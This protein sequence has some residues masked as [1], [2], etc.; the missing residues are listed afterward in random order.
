MILKWPL[1]H[2]RIRKLITTIGH[3]GIEIVFSSP[4]GFKAPNATNEKDPTVAYRLLKLVETYENN[5]KTWLKNYGVRIN[6]TELKISTSCGNQQVAATEYQHDR[7][8]VEKPNQGQSKPKEADVTQRLSLGTKTLYLA[9]SNPFE[10]RWGAGA[11]RA[12][13]SIVQFD[14]LTHLWI[15]WAMVNTHYNKNRYQPLDDHPLLMVIDPEYWS[16]LTW[17]LAQRP[18]FWKFKKRRA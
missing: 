12:S 8:C 5:T 10:S 4:K 13:W 1:L 2:Q 3:V 7:K 9:Q 15:T 16:L 6:I 18:L 11:P 17:R 14:S